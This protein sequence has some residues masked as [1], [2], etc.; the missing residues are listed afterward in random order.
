MEHTGETIVIKYGGHA[1]E[2]A[3]A[4]LQFAK[5]VVLLKSCGV[6][7]VIVHGGGPQI[8]A[9]LGRLNIETSF[10]EGLRV[11][12]TDTVDVAEMVLCG[13]INKGIA[14]S[15]KQAGGRA[16]GLSGKDDN[17]I[18][19]DKLQ[20]VITDP[21]TGIS[22]MLD[23]GYVGEIKKVNTKIISDLVAAGIIPVIAPIGVD[24]RG[25]TYNCNADTAA[26]AIA[27]ALKANR[28]LLLTDVKGVLSKE[29]ELFEELTTERVSELMRD[30]TITGGMIP[31]LNTAVNAVK[32]GV[33]AA[34]ILDGRAR[35][36]LL[37]EL[38]TSGGAGTLI[39]S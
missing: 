39:K 10:V 1:M 14:S 24:E 30:G 36:A 32:A 4:S 22:K 29:G 11:T 13:K 26:G 23:L 35:H 16:I 18:L 37:L 5:D 2:D 28:L 21:G 17:L 3:A 33:G 19:A 20:K 27:G 8:A 31:K 7:P 15:I 34:I 9:M 25:Q 38:Y 6:N 12:D